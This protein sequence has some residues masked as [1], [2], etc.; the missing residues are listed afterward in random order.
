MQLMILVLSACVHHATKRQSS[1]AVRGRGWRMERC[2][3][4]ATASLSEHVK[5]LNL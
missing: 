4:S 3:I 1:L 2:G 5:S